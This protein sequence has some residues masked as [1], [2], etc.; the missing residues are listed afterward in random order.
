MSRIKNKFFELKQKNEKALIA[1]IMVGYPNEKSTIS[2]ING[3]IKGGA[4]IIIKKIRKETDIPLV[5]MT[6]T[7]I[8]YKIGYEKFMLKAKNVGID[9]FILPDMSLEESKNYVTAARKNKLDTIFLISPNTSTKRIKKIL[10]VTSGFLYLVSMYGTTGMQTKIQKYTIDAIKKTK[11][12]V[13]KKKPI[14]IGFGVNTPQDAKKFLSLGVDAVIVG[15]AFLRLLEKT[16]A[17]KIESKI[18]NF[19]RSLKNTT[20]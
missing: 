11:R 14:G 17:K 8:L 18:T 16:P 9:G 3:L 6:Y 7:N 1:Y 20:R 4:D 13:N 10:K 15:S 12:V 19:T 5:L 2:A